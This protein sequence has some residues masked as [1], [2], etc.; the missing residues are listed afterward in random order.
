MEH[1]T[2]EPTTRLERD[3]ST[4]TI[5]DIKKFLQAGAHEIP[6]TEIM[7]FWK[8]CSAEERLDIKTSVARWDGVSTFVN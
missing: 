3:P 4:I 2:A 5:N 6:A 7:Q 1:V 8:A